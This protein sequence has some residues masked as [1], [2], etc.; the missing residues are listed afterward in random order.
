ME[1]VV[2]SILTVIAIA[3]AVL[4]GSPSLADDREITVIPATGYGI[5]FLGFNPPGDDDW[6]DNELTEA[7]VDGERI[8][9]PFDTAKEGCK[10]TMRIDW[11][12]PGY[13]AVIWLDINVC[14]IRSITMEYDNKT[15]KTSITTR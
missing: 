13:P 7:L 15:A 10:W 5:K 9:V 8:K 6:S 12:E 11:S 4:S 1:I 2:R 14:T 3:F